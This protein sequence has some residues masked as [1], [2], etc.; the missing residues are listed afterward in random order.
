LRS[1]ISV[2]KSRKRS[3]KGEKIRNGKKRNENINK[4]LLEGFSLGVA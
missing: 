3:M 4:R 1:G 2:E